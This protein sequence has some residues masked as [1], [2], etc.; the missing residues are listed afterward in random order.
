MVTSGPADDTEEFSPKETSA[1][2]QHERIDPA[3][4]SFIMDLNLEIME[5]LDLPSPISVSEQVTL[6]NLK[7]AEVQTVLPEM[8]GPMHTGDFNNKVKLYVM[9]FY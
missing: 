4:S 8:R 6:R 7:S 9:I 3:N 1:S 5:P 2:L